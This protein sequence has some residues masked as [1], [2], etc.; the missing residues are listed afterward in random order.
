MKKYRNRLRL[1]RGAAVMLLVAQPLQSASAQI[2][3]TQTPTLQTKP[4][5]AQTPA[6]QPLVP[7]PEIT[8]NGNP[9][10]ASGIVQ[11]A[12]PAPPFLPRAVAPPVGDI[13]ISNFDS[14]PDL[15]NL[16]T[17]VLVPR[18]VL[19]EAPVREVLGLLARSAGLNL[20]FSEVQGDP[21][22]VLLGPTISL[23][24]ENE[25]V[26]DVFNTVLQL[27][28][29]QA[30]RRGNTIFVGPT[31][32]DAAQNLISRTLRLNQVEA[33]NAAAFL[34]SQGAQAQQL[35]IPITEIIDPETN[36]V[37]QR[38]EEP[39]ELRPLTVIPEEGSLAPLLLTGLAV[40]NDDRL[41]SITLV[42]DPRKVEIATSLLIQLDARRRQA[43]VNVKVVD[44]DLFN[45]N[46]FNSSFAFGFDDG[47][48]VQ[49]EGT[50]ILNFGR[51]N[52]PNAVD[53]RDSVFYPTVVPF[54]ETI[55]RGTT[56]ELA[57]FFDR[58][59][60]PF[61][62]ITEGQVDALG[63]RAPFARPNFG[64]FNNPFQPG[65]S[66]VTEDDIEFSL[67]GLFRYPDR[68]LLTLQS[69]IES[70]NAK[71]LTDPTLVVQ[72]G[73][74]ATVKLVQDVVTSVDTQV[75]PLSGVRT[76]TPVLEEAGLILTVNIERIDDNGFL[77]LAVVP[78]V[79]APGPP[80]VFDSGAGSQNVITPLQ[81][82]Q[83]SS[84]L[85]R[86][87][88][89]QTLILS[90]II[91]ES[92]ITQVSKVPIFG[93]LPIL[94]ALFRSTDQQSDRT[95]VV[96]M[97]TPQIVED[98]PRPGTGYNYAPGRDAADMLRQRGFPVQG[99]PKY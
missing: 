52:P 32:P 91:Q 2:R 33:E 4:S 23:D 95:E 8:I 49:D 79:S 44:I 97:V 19:R 86:L 57:P 56:A 38:R 64:T 83:L 46:L 73:Q 76:T 62:D 28:G 85:I 30:N 59:N 78:T 37:V 12:A 21:G 3:S 15:I 69:Q 43:A 35:V 20:V 7:N 18:L 26:Q 63:R 53:A 1:L 22:A 13:A 93:D 82:R 25:P 74:E 14:S 60:A 29:L 39:A 94:G 70:G 17:T 45:T 54:Q 67:P 88:D 92:D 96:V 6:A 51:R 31:L 61:G 87:R 11:P 90:G 98:S 10:P 89:T 41:N 72:E 55:P 50:A 81:V 75:D 84:G 34:A 27:S 36:R 9:A 48:F 68:F 16:G 77:A 5:I 58:Q 42:G 80:I 99:K 66:E 47:F 71:I 24:L 65:V 40:S